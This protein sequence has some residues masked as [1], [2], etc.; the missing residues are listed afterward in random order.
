[1]KRRGHLFEEICSFKNLLLA[2]KKAQ[3]GKRFKNSTAAFN[4]EIE[5]NLLSLQEKLLFQTYRLGRYRHFFVFDPKQRFINA[6]PYADRVVQHALCNVIE[7]IFD[8][9]LI[10]DS[11]ACRKGK[12]THKAVE[13]FTQ[14]ARRN[15]YVLKCDI[16]SYFASIDHKLLFEMIERKIKD[17]NT[18]WLIKVI[19]DSTENPGIP[20][21][22]LT[23]QIFA[24]LYLSGLDHF[25]KEKL[26]VRAYLRYMDDL[27][28]FDND[29]LRLTSW[30]EDIA[31]YLA[32]LKLEIHQNKSQIYQTRR[33]VSFLGYK[34]YAT[35]RLV[36]KQNI[37]RF[38]RR[39][40]KYLQFF[41]TN[42]MT[43]R[44]INDSIQSWLG[45][46]GQ[47]D[48]YNLKRRLLAEFD[49]QGI[50]P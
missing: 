28:L 11:F 32:G 27:I 48:S 34:V 9:P 30:K 17:P 23:S 29:K 25:I 35:H 1:M 36:V 22:N 39:M 33:G 10:G 15:N 14:F 21:G 45:Y 24:N 26:K 6:A 47:A 41:W 19:I 13:R 38:R 3:R 49:F 4:L 42:L 40:R 50:S 16:K 7:P 37:C 2:A 5:K 8:R 31:D 43:S 12:G 44:E 20:I 46:A 18:L